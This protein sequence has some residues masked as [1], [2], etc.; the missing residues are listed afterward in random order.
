MRDQR[1]TSQRIALT[2]L[3]GIRRLPMAL[4]SILETK[5]EA[6][7]PR[8]LWVQ[9]ARKHP[10]RSMAENHQELGVPMDCKSKCSQSC[11]GNG[12][13]RRCGP[14]EGKRTLRSTQPLIRRKFFCQKSRRERNLTFRFSQADRSRQRTAAAGGADGMLLAFPCFL[15]ETVDLAVPSCCQWR[16]LVL[17][18]PIC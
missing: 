4:W 6:I 7:A 1:N 8:R 11:S 17:R 15:T 13:R 5:R 14:K 16:R 12:C 9:Q 2:R 3:E 18:L 10:P